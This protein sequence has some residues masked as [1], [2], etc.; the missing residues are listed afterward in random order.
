MFLVEF[1][2]VV[3]QPG[4]LEELSPK[5]QQVAVALERLPE[6]LRE[7]VLLKRYESKTWREV[8]EV[9]GESDSTSRRRYVRAIDALREMLT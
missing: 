1:K 6:D 8:A 5:E 9:L 4:S 2:L 3:P 7:V